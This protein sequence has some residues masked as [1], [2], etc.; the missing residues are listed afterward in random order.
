[1]IQVPFTGLN[2]AWFHQLPTIHCAM[3][4]MAQT[5]KGERSNVAADA[6]KAFGIG[7]TAGLLGSLAGMG[8][9]FVMIPMMTSMLRLS[10]HQAHGTS[11]FAVAA[12]GLAGAAS[13]GP[14]VQWEPAVAVAL[15]GM[16]TARM[17]ARATTTMSEQA[18]KRALGILMLV[19]SAAVPAKAYL[20]EQYKE[21]ER[22]DSQ[23]DDANGMSDRTETSTLG[24]VAP[25]AAIGTCSGFMAGLFGVGGG[26]IVVPALTLF[27]TC[28]HY[29]ALATSLAAMTLPALAGTWTH[30][31]AGNVALRA[32]PALAAGALV[33][34]AVGG[35]IGRRTNE[36]TL[37]WGFSSLLAILGIRT[38]LKA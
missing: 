21:K 2:I 25:A 35:Q 5:V 32:A 26:V 13:Y 12:T 33:G 9:G 19:M 37:R 27:T 16:V 30:H 6:A 38:L 4:V 24:R 28:N 10:Q 11:L 29:E 31:R 34:A 22:M 36:S 17:G 14:A 1:M 15:T 20:M 18:L 3:L 23:N 8:G 7:S